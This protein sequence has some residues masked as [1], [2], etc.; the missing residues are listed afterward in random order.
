MAI[1]AQD[2]QNHPK[3]V[4]DHLG[5]FLSNVTGFK[6][7][8]RAVTNSSGVSTYF[9]RLSSELAALAANPSKADGTRKCIAQDEKGKSDSIRSWGLSNMGV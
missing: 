8:N 3:V 7:H 4:A 5:L 1:T 9:Q 6:V 2:M